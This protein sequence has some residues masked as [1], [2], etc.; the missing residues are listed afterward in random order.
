LIVASFDGKVRAVDPLT[1]N[2]IDDFNLGYDYSAI[3]S[4]LV[5]TDDYLALYSSRNR[6]YLFQ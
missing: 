3:F 5:T 6:L 4:D 2:V 1:L